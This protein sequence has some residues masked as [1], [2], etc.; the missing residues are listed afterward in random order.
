MF[1]ESCSQSPARGINTPCLK[2]ATHFVGVV[3]TVL[4][5][6][7]AK[8]Q[9]TTPEPPS[10]KLIDAG[11]EP[12]KA[13]RFHVKAGHKE[14]MVMTMKMNMDMP[15]APAAAQS[16]SIPTLTMP[17]DVTVPKVAPNGD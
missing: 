1:K 15:G 2:R 6:S 3:V 11:S 10:V 16:M 8:A 14:S 17:M 12:R 5:M 13:L 4:F 7:A 9:P